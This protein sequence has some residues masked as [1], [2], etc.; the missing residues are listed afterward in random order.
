MA[1]SRGTNRFVYWAPPAHFLDLGED[2]FASASSLSVIASTYHEPPSGSAIGHA[3]FRRPGS[4]GTECHP[5]RRSVGSAKVSS[6]ALVCRD[7]VPPSTRR[8]RL[9]GHPGHVLRGFV[10]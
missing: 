10:R 1:I 5:D 8:H 2:R 4:A 6:S 9:I 3:Q 7:C